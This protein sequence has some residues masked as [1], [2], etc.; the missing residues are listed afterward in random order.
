VEETYDV[1]FTPARPAM[2]RLELRRG[3]NVLVTM[4][5]EVR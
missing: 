2:L 4:P 1:D 5:V 3:P